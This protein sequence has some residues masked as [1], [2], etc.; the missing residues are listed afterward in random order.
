RFPRSVQ[1]V[2]V[3]VAE[4]VVTRGFDGMTFEAHFFVSRGRPGA[5]EPAWIWR[6][7]LLLR[8]DAHERSTAW[9]EGFCAVGAGKL[10]ALMTL[11][12][13]ASAGEESPAPTCCR[14]L[15]IACRG[16]TIGS[17]LAIGAAISPNVSGA[18]L[19]SGPPPRTIRV[20]LDA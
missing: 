1:G 8:D 10:N 14:T 17:P 7:A 20:S 18:L 6:S 2:R 11:C 4:V 16:H 9:S 13:L 5:S 12:P 19:P 3:T 15:L